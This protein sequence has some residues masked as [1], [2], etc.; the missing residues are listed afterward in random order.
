MVPN[1]QPNKSKNGSQTSLIVT[2]VIICILAAGIA[3]GWAY[4]TNSKPAWYVKWQIQRYLKQQSGKR[5]FQTDFPFPSK[6]EMQTVPDVLKTNKPSENPIGKLTK[7]DLKTLRAEVDVLSASNKTLTAEIDNLRKA[8]DK[9]KAELSANQGATN[10]AQQTGA[11]S[12]PEIADLQAKITAKQEQLTALR[13]QIDTCW[14]DIKEIQTQINAQQQAVLAS[15][16]LAP[17]N[18]LVV[19]QTEFIKK[20][21]EKLNQATTYRAMYEVIGQE[22][23][24][25]DNLLESMNPA[26]RKVGLAVARQAALDSQN[27]AENYWLSARIYEG[28]L[29]PN[30]YDATD[31]NWKMPLSM[32][33]ILNEAVQSFRNV[34]ETNNVIRAY[35]TMIEK[36]GGSARADWSRVQLSIIYEQMGDLKSAIEYLKDIQNTNN[37][38]AQI[39]RIP[40]LEARLNPQPKPKQK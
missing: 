26:H 6:K 39:R 4:I 37:F 16:T 38:A 2:I 10:T 12:P 22:L 8:L 24:V 35:Q 11:S 23:W 34:E 9:K 36:T 15:L 7:K 14:Q 21:R 3:G 5:S 20:T 25:A 31:P 30:L 17:T 27:Y 29:L 32:E 33:N 19:A 13:K 18:P 28:Y 1:N 40:A